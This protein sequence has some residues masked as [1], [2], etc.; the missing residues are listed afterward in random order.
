MSGVVRKMTFGYSYFYGNILFANEL[1]HRYGEKGLISIS[2]NPG[3]IKNTGLKQHMDVL[4]LASLSF[5]MLQLYEPELGA[6]TQLYAGTSPECE[7]MNGKYL[8]P[9]CQE[10]MM[11]PSANDPKSAGELWKWMEEENRF[12]F[13][14]LIQFPFPAAGHFLRV[15]RFGKLGK[16]T[17]RTGKRNSYLEFVSW[18]TEVEILR[19][20]S[21]FY[22]QSSEHLH[23]SQHTIRTNGGLG[24]ECL[25]KSP[26]LGRMGH[27]DGVQVSDIAWKMYQDLKDEC[28]AIFTAVKLSKKQKG[29]GGAGDEE[30][31][32]N[33]E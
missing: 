24:A 17:M 26:D 1:A 12:M 28:E 25:I 13:S 15:L 29:Q 32:E 6:L 18:S 31:N 23:L 14:R 8:K 27:L 2:L 3:N 20:Q 30:I 19:F 4:S 33:F 7:N 21:E 22:G 16:D 5:W 10:G 9:W 11:R